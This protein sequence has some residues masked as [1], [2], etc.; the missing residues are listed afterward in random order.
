MLARISCAGY[1]LGSRNKVASISISVCRFGTFR[2]PWH[3]LNFKVTAGAILD[4]VAKAPEFADELVVI[5]VFDVFP[6]QQ[7]FVIL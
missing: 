2:R 5:D 3:T 4:F 7:Q 6:R 1:L